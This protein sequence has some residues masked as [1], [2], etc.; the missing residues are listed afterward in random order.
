[1]FPKFFSLGKSFQLGASQASGVLRNTLWGL[2]FESSRATGELKVTKR[3]SYLGKRREWRKPQRNKYP[4]VCGP[5]RLLGSLDTFSR[6]SLTTQCDPGVISIFSAFL[7]FLA[8]A[9]K[10]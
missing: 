3:S 1:M 7:S 6:G 5:G 9:L 4:P 10:R 8:Q 2:L